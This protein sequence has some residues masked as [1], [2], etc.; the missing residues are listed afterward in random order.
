LGV[1][2]I[3]GP[4]P[5]FA[6]FHGGFAD[7]SAERAAKKASTCGVSASTDTVAQQTPEA[8]RAIS[9]LFELLQID[10]KKPVNRWLPGEGHKAFDY[11]DAWSGELERMLTSCGPH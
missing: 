8:N 11:A 6:F 1:N 5:N 4:G 2:G 10:K 7:G 9:P 3:A